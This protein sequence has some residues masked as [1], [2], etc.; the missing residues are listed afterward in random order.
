M[1]LAGMD[2]LRVLRQIRRDDDNIRREFLFSQSCSKRYPR[3]I[4]CLGTYV[5]DYLLE[6]EPARA[7][8]FRASLEK[9]HQEMQSGLESYRAQLRPEEQKPYQ[10]MIAELSQYWKV[11]GADFAVERG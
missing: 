5:R 4:A 7:E 9:V 10:E 2:A 8:A 6:P 3:S 11:F 1:A